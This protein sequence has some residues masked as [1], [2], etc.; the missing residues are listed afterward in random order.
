M[1]SVERGV[2]KMEK[3]FTMK[4]K[5]DEILKAYDDLLAKYGEKKEDTDEIKVKETK[6]ETVTKKTI[7]EEPPAY[8]IESIVQGLAN[9]KLN[10]NK[11]LT[12]ISDKLITEVNKLEAIKKEIAIETKNLEDIHNIQIKGDTLNAFIQEQEEKKKAFGEEIVSIRA[13]WEKE[14]E[15]YE[16]AVKER[17]EKLKKERDR[18]VEEYT[19]N[20]SLTRRKGRDAYEEEKTALKKAL[21]EER[22]TK[23]KELLERETE[24][25]AQEAEIAEWKARVKTFP[26][27]LE[28]TVKK[29]EKETGFKLEKEMKQGAELLAKEIEGEKKVSELKIKNLEDTMMKQVLQI[30]V[31]TKQLSISSDHVLNI[32]SK[33][34]EGASGAKPLASVNEMAL[35]QTKDVNTKK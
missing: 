31:L 5:K 22:E 12:N 20:L 15:E 10:L 34:I 11:T 24:I 28:E 7:I 2:I 19:Y 18:E 30:D 23:M 35:E 3:K 9:L 32:A 4:T 16:M 26:I 29:V 14:Q 33:A 25:A 17:D 13:Q 27:E 8:T 1:A 21:K 6:V